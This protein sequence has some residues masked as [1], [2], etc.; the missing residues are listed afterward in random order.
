MKKALVISLA[1][2]LFTLTA[3]ANQPEDLKVV[4][5]SCGIQA[6]QVTEADRIQLRP[7]AIME[8]SKVSEDETTK[9]SQVVMYQK[10]MGGFA[11]SEDKK[12][13][14]SEESAQLM[15]PVK[16]VV[17]RNKADNAVISDQTTEL[18]KEF[19]GS[20]TITTRTE[21]KTQAKDTMIVIKGSEQ[22]PKDNLIMQLQAMK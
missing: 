8:F 9:C 10:L 1:L 20:A 22:C 5:K 13:I 2:S 7:N 6:L 4:N 14:R 12:S 18:S 16:R 17:C 11:K 21:K 15:M 19:V 3:A